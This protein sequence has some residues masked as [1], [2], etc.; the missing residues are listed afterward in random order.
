MTT[1][2]ARK[3]WREAAKFVLTRPMLEIRVCPLLP[4]PPFSSSSSPSSPVALRHPRDRNESKWR[5]RTLTTLTHFRRSRRRARLSQK[6]VPSLSEDAP[7]GRDVQSER[8]SAN[9][10]GI[11]T[12][13]QLRLTLPRSMYARASA[14]GPFNVS[15]L[16]LSAQVVVD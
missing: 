1:G 8:I 13:R 15:R 2:C 10:R 4:S 16:R 5:H 14:D 12:R 9:A 6:V 11:F 3:P 7:D